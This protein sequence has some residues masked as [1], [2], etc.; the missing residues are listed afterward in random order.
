MLRVYVETTRVEST[1]RILDE[2]CATVKKL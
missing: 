2:V 1:K